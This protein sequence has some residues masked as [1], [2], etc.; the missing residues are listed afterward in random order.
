MRSGGTMIKINKYILLLFLLLVPLAEG[1]LC[2]NEV[3]ITQNCTMLTP[4]VTGC[5]DYNYTIIN[6][7]SGVILEEDA[8]ISLQDDIYYFNFSQPI[9][10]YIVKLCDDSTREITVGVKSKMATWEIALVFGLL[11]AAF[12]LLLLAFKGDNQ[13]LPL[14]LAFI[15]GAMGFLLFALQANIAIID[16]NEVNI[17]DTTAF[18]GLIGISEG[19]YQVML[20][21]LWLFIAITVI[22]TLFVVVGYLKKSRR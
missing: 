16:A 13:Q 18:N 4:V 20:Y 17:D 12:F 1:H 8:L 10:G 3:P 22:S 2:Q 11:A 21:I 6:S 19:A 15:T 7:T 5:S 14:K 9:G